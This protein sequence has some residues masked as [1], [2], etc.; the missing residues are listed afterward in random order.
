MLVVMSMIKC[1]ATHFS[2]FGVC[3][4]EMEKGKS[5]REIE[6]VQKG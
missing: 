4:S 1:D 6:E 5:K 2:M 3:G